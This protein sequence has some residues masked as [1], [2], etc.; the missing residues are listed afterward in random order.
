MHLRNGRVIG[1]TLQET[2]TMSVNKIPSGT[3]AHHR[4]AT[5]KPTVAER[6][7]GHKEA[8]PQGTDLPNVMPGDSPF[9]TWDQFQSAMTVIRTVIGGTGAPGATTP[10]LSEDGSTMQAFLLRIERRYTQMGLEPR[11]WGN[12][13]ID[14]LV[15]PALTHCMYLR[16]TIDLSDGA[17]VQRRLLERF[18]RT[19]SQ[20][21]LLTELTK[22]RW[23]G[24]PKEYTDQFAAVA[25]RGLGLAPDEIA[26]YYCA[27][28]PTGLHL[29]IT[30]NGHVKCH[31]GHAEGSQPLLE[32]RRES[33][34]ASILSEE[35]PDATTDNRKKS[36]EATEDGYRSDAT[37]IVPHW[38]REACTKES[39]DQG[40]AF[41][42]VGAMAVLRVELAGSPSLGLDWL[43][44]HKVAWYFQSD[45]LRTYVNGQ[46]C[47]LPVLRTCEATLQGDSPTVVHPRTPEEQAYEILAKQVAGIS[48]EEAAI[49]LRPPPRR[50]K[51]HAKTKAKARITSLLRQAAADT[52]DLKAPLYGL[53]LILALPE[54]GFA[55]PLRLSDEWQDA[56]CC[57]LIGNQPTSSGWRSPS[58]STAS[59]AAESDEESPW[60]MAKLEHTLFDE[61]I[62]SPEAQDIP[63]EV[64]QVLY[65][66]RAVF[67]DTLPKGLPPKLPHD[68]HILLVPGKLPAKSAIYRMTPYQLTFHK[69]EILKLSENGWIGPTYSP[70]RSPTIMVNKRENG[71]RSRR[72]RTHHPFAMATRP[73][74][75][76]FNHA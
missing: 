19:M 31:D 33:G 38:W 60:P 32:T 58:A 56:L 74:T 52:K 43:T 18:D 55:V 71:I 29:L 53:H 17:T 72:Y 30:N 34:S 63:C 68:R 42:C 20:S 66:Y 54:A 73:R 49:F 1:P 48:A 50:F 26:D 15:G 40:G 11:E 75:L 44:E 4:H 14:H 64:A 57:A 35:T 8:P 24:D 5:Q 3:P 45:K 28:L 27:G 76:V 59:V 62:T 16:R 36:A 61:W 21:Q 46:W 51:S 10:I 6:S 41:C 9:V 47:E 13:L 65:E 25:E 37:E 69:Q 70:I 67:P 2:P 12:A 23:N 22:V 39:Y 7:H